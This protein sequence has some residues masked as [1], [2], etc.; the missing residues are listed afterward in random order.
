MNSHPFSHA[1]LLAASLAASLAAGSLRADAP[2]APPPTDPFAS[3]PSWTDAVLAAKPFLLEV[4]AGEIDADPASIKPTARLTPEF[5]AAAR[6]LRL[7]VAAVDAGAAEVPDRLHLVY[8][9][10]PDHTD[11]ALEVRATLR[12]REA[13]V[14]EINTRL[15]LTPGGDWVVLGG[16]TREQVTVSEG[17]TPSSRRNLLFAF[18]VLPAPDPS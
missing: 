15:T 6:R 13:G 2:A 1:F 10:E 16:L 4:A 17:V 3:G 7:R 18:R 5:L 14:R 9:L 8:R 11:L 12:D